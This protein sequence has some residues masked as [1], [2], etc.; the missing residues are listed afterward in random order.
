MEWIQK[1]GDTFLAPA[2]DKSNKISGFRCWEQAF[3]MYATIYCGANP[4][5]SKEIWQYISVINT[6]AS[7]YTWE[8]FYN[9]DVVFHHLMAFNPQR[10]W[11]ITYNQMWNL[12]MRD[13]L[14]PRGSNP[15]RFSSV[16][17]QNYGGG[18][19]QPRKSR[20]SIY[21]W[22]YNKGIPCKFGRNC[23]FIER[24][25]FCDVGDHSLYNCPKADKKDKEK[26][27][28]SAGFPQTR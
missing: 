26:L 13:P 6:A 3:R 4:H 16:S 21:C 19:G 5:C 27:K 17:N 1:D 12:S 24:C 15:T 14:P 7:S 23:K 8:N 9:Y 22:N 28:I 18:K 25:S 20:K 10:S 2:T 11:S